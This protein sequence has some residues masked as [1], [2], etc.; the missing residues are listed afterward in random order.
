MKYY[1]K[2]TDEE[3]EKINQGVLLTEW[4]EDLP[5]QVSKAELQHGY[6][7]QTGAR[8][9]ILP[10]WY[11]EIKEDEETTRDSI[12]AERMELTA[13][14]F[15]KQSYKLFDPE[16]YTKKKDEEIKEQAKKLST[17]PYYGTAK[18]Y[19]EHFNKI[20]NPPHYTEDRKYE[21][22]AVIEDWELNFHL[23][24]VLKYISR[25]GRKGEELEDLK[26]ARWYLDRY[27]KTLENE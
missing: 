18:E 4:W 13:G 2:R 24:N 1:R 14:Q 10:E 6:E 9:V 27:I 23:G 3:M 26:K 15:N 19:Q 12:D 21:P 25:A 5:E 16:Q 22:I 20:F 11:E 8:W 17:E 7:N